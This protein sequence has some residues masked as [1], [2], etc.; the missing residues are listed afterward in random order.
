MTPAHHNNINPED[1][2]MFF[3]KVH[4]KPKISEKTP[5]ADKPF[6]IEVRKLG[7]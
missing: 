3:A 5:S 6:F 2:H 1:I 4:D 7:Q